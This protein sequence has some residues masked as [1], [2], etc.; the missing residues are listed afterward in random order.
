VHGWNC[1]FEDNIE[2]IRKEKKNSSQ[3]MNYSINDLLKGFFEF[4]VNFFSTSTVAA[5]F[6]ST[7]NAKM[8]DLNDKSNCAL[9]KQ[10]IYLN[11]QDPFDLNHNLT[12]N[13]SKGTIQRFITECRGSNDLL[14]Y[15]TSTQHKSLTKSWGLML[16]MTRKSLTNYNN[17]TTLT[18][19]EIDSQPLVDKST[20]KLNLKTTTSG[21]DEQNIN[22]SMSDNCETSSTSMIA[23]EKSKEFVLFLFKECLLFDELT[24]D[25]MI[26]KKQKR[27]I[28][29]ICD[30]V[31]SMELDQS[32]KRL[33][34]TSNSNTN[35]YFCTI[36][37]SLNNNHI[38]SNQNADVDSDIEMKDKSS[39]SSI[40][41]Y[42]FNTKYNTWQGRRALKRELKQQ[43]VDK[44]D[45]EIEKCISDK[46]K[47]KLGCL[48]DGINFKIK[49]ITNENKCSSEHQTN[50][51]SLQMKFELLDETDK[52]A[53]LI[54]FT[55]LVHF[56]DIYINNC[57]EKFFDQWKSSITI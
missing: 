11:I 6:I 42:Q 40:V 13:I 31:D 37:D 8:V 39:N 51:K 30:K 1:A 27:A 12:G 52:Q 29:K 10:S 17:T 54:N 23:I 28:N 38:Q 2:K 47:Q 49:F 16:L 34:L 45:I 55:T 36:D 7:R 21:E 46:L 57:H 26:F 20:Q 32:P 48:E 3:Q 35:A 50:S 24:G 9:S 44:S 15:S 18:K 22:P 41:S 14:H 56:L 19:I 4:Y 5:H 43:K 25:R 53:D 33:K